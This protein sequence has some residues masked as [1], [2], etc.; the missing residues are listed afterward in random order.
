M[1]AAAY[2]LKSLVLVQSALATALTMAVAA[3]L[4]PQQGASYG[5]G[6]L[7]MLTNLLL[8]AWIWSRY[9]AK[10]SIAWT[11]VIIVGKYTVLLSAIFLLSQRAWFHVLS[12]G[13]GMVTFVTA[14]LVQVTYVNRE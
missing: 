5:L 8:L 10:K 11:V 6:S 2:S 1:A 3:A 4:G 7:L 13:L 9:L 12:S 14:C